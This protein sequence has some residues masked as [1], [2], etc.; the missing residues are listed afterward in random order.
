[1]DDFAKR[2]TL[3]LVAVAVLG[4]AWWFFSRDTLGGD[5]NA[6]LEHDAE[7]AGYPYTFRVISVEEG[8]ATV[9]SP[10][11]AQVSV[12]QFLRTAFPDLADMPVDHPEMMAAQEKLVSMQSRAA[13]IITASPEVSA[14]QWQIDEK[15]YA[16]RGAY[17][18]IAR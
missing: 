15:W 9:S 1:M 17:I 6:M 7:L 14:I 2:Y 5:I 8:V 3:I 18:D 4:L 10:R 11:S 12:I 16:S 13:E